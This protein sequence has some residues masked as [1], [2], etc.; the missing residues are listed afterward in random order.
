MQDSFLRM[1]FDEDKEKTG[2][3]REL[4]LCSQTNNEEQCMENGFPLVFQ[5]RKKASLPKHLS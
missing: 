3:L 5:K 1:F 2:I 4:I